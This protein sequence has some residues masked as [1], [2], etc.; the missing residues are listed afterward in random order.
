MPHDAAKE[1]WERHSSLPSPEELVRPVPAQAPLPSPK[2][3][4]VRV[5]Q[6]PKIV[7]DTYQATI[8]RMETHHMHVWEFDFQLDKPMP[9]VPGQYVSIYLPQMKPAPFS[10][11]SSP[12]ETKHIVLGIEVVGP[13]T[14][15]LAK[16]EPGSAVTLK[17]PFGRFVM[18]DAERKVCF[19]AGG[20]GITPF[21]SMLRS[22]RDT[23]DTRR[24]VLFYCCK[25]RDQFMWL[26]EMLDIARACPNVTVVLSLTQEQPPAGGPYRAGRISEPLIRETIPDY[27]DFT[28]FSCGPPALIDAMFKVL[29]GMGV[30]Q[31]RLRRE[32]WH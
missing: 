30:S 25:T 8:T 3:D 24:A 12:A 1:S 31:E 26:D 9:F 6:P 28:F 5:A 4:E 18:A 27:T 14:G 32:A 11:A 23:K 17:G 22:I 7:F 29:G 2:P 15:Q 19:L 16:L 20:I 21:M 13:V 10:I